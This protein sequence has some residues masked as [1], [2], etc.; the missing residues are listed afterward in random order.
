MS[1]EPV[2]YR[3]STSFARAYRAFVAVERTARQAIIDY[4][5]QHPGRE[6]VVQKDRVDHEITIVGFADPDRKQ[7]PPDGL[8]RSAKRDYLIP[9]RGPSGEPWRKVIADLSA[10]PELGETVFRPHRVSPYFIDSDAGLIRTAGI[11]DYGEHGVFLRIGAPY[12]KMSE[13]LTPVPLSEFY[14]AK[15]AHEAD[16]QAV[17][18]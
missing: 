11:Y 8:S 12:P 13:H 7:P 9:Q 5:E 18:R 6:L 16:E 17:V 3:V 10:F 15:E 14:A 4:N 2:A 1:T